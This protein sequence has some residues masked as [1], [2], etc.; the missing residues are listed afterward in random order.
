MAR[1]VSCELRAVDLPFRMPFK[2]AAATRTSSASLFLKC[3]TETGACGYGEALPR[4]YVTGESQDST[5]EL[6]RQQLLPRLA[7]RRFDDLAHVVAFLQE[8][9]GQSPAGWRVETIP[10]TAAWCAV[11]LALL[12][13][14]G[15]H[16]GTSVELPPGGDRETRGST[17]PPH[18]HPA[19]GLPTCSAVVSSEASLRTLLLIRLAGIRQVKLKLERNGNASAAARC[20]RILGEKCE[21]RADA[22]MAWDLENAVSEMTRLS[23]FGIR[24]FE[25]P[26]PAGELADLAALVQQT[27]DLE[28]V[29]DESLNTR[30]SLA[31]LIDQRACTAV[32]VRIAKCGGL[33][34]SQRRCQQALAAG[35]GVQLGCQVGESSLLA[36][37]QLRLLRSVAPV[38]HLEGCYGRILLRADPAAPILQFGYRGRPPRFPPGPGFG[39]TID[40]AIL[41]QA[42]VRCERIDF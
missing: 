28:V 12:D 38:R 31:E 33:I 1:I 21:I 13:A 42:T 26:L 39:I 32:N 7:D 22:N 18:G 37:A 25:Q 16:F 3:T 27:P 8:C 2:H 34:A 20:R 40:E 17:E 36:A 24:S 4:D 5:F 29:V 19:N 41:E 15:H 35:L 6:L 11:D 30:E 9:D 23:E 14:F 10:H